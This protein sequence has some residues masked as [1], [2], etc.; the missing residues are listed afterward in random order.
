MLG[1][2]WILTFSLSDGPVS[3]I[4]AEF[5]VPISCILLMMLTSVIPVHLPRF[6]G[7]LLFVFS[8]LLLFSFFRPWIWGVLVLFKGLIDFLQFLFVFPSISLKVIFKFY[9]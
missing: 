5:L 8:L 1:I 6:P 2:F 7:I 9:L 4:S 3:S